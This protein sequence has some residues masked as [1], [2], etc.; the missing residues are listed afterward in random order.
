[1]GY[2]ALF[3]LTYPFEAGATKMNNQEIAGLCTTMGVYG[4]VAV[5]ILFAIAHYLRGG[6]SD[7][8]DNSGKGGKKK[9]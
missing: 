8:G 5:A 9:E 6:P 4:T 2:E 1:M 3:P 7:K